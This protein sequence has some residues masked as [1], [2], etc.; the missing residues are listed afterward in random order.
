MQAVPNSGTRARVV[1]A[2]QRRLAGAALAKVM[3]LRRS[4]APLASQLVLVAPA[5]LQAPGVGGLAK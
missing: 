2:E 1:D 4:G 3:T 5:R